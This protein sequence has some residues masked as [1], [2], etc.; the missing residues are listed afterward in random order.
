M[1]AISEA[2]CAR[3]APCGAMRALSRVVVIGG[4]LVAGWMLGSGLALASDDG[5]GGQLGAPPTVASALTSAGAAVSGVPSRSVPPLARLGFLTRIANAVDVAKP[6]ARVL[7]SQGL[8][9]QGLASHSL[10]PRTLALLSGPAQLGT[11]SSAPAEA[12]QAPPLDQPATR[13]AVAPAPGPA[14][15]PSAGHVTVHTAVNHSRDSATS[16]FARPLAVNNHPAPSVP[17]S[18]VGSTA[19][20]SMT[21]GTGSGAGTN[22][23]PHAAMSGSWASARL[24]QLC[25]PRYRNASDLPRSPAEQ[26]STSPD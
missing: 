10:A 13:A 25:R 22:S 4:L 5:P 15:W 8:V 6:V 17:V 9:S 21:G 2:G 19:S 14:L 18:P 26:P 16:V 23:A 20:A 12:P 24:G 7:E 11:G 1:A 3:C